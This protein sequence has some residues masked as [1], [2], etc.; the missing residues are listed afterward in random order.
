MSGETKERI[1][2][3]I[4]VFQMS[5]NLQIRVEYRDAVCCEVWM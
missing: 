5:L 1:E 2:E 4:E 3:K